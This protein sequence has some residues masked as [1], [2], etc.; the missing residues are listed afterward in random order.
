MS[1]KTVTENGY[2][3]LV[4]DEE[5][6]AKAPLGRYFDPQ[7]PLLSKAIAKGGRGKALIYNTGS[8]TVV[9]RHYRRGGFF[10]HFVKDHFFL[11]EPHAHRAFDEMRLLYLMGKKSL[12]VPRPIVARERIVHGCV[13]QDIVIGALNAR[14]LS[15]VMRD[16]ALTRIEMLRL[17]GMIKA[18]FEQGIDHTDLNIRNILLDEQGKFYLIDFDKCFLSYP[19][20]KRRAEIIE[21]LHRS[22][23]KELKRYPD[24]I[25]YKDEDFV[26]IEGSALS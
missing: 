3:Y 24:A 19:S 18:F 21:R 25:H 22:F 12:P 9:L 4:N 20:Y 13:V 5:P 10:G 26:L 8:M 15:Y 2:K 16:R 17:G 11:C 7:D 23:L 14:D 6:T 1:L